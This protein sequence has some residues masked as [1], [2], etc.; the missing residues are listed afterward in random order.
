MHQQIK[1][2]NRAGEIALHQ[3]PQFFPDMRFWKQGGQPDGG[4]GDDKDWP[5][6]LGYKCSHSFPLRRFI[7]IK[8]SAANLNTMGKGD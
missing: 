7:S 3:H 6:D 5:I 1:P 8:Q 4:T 2:I